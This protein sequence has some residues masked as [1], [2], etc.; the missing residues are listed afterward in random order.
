MLR[1]LNILIHNVMN[2]LQ[3]VAAKAPLQVVHV[4]AFHVVQ[5][6]FALVPLDSLRSIALESHPA[7]KLC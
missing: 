7:L 6:V 3:L 2:L 1:L 4:T 5:T